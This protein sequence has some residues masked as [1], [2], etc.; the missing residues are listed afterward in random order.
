MRL[1]PTHLPVNPWENMPGYGNV[2]LLTRMA[3]VRGSGYSVLD[4]QETSQVLR[5]APRT[6]RD[7]VRRCCQYGLFRHIQWNGNNEVKIF[8]SALAKVATAYSGPGGCRVLVRPKDLCNKKAIIVEA[9][10]KTRQKRSFYQQFKEQQAK[11]GTKKPRMNSIGQ[12]FGSGSSLYAR[13]TSPILFRTQRFTFV[14]SEFTVFGT[15]QPAI[16][17]EMGRHERT[18]RRRLSNAYRQRLT[19]RTRVEMEPLK[20]AQLAIQTRMSPDML[21]FVQGQS[22]DADPFFK[23]YGQVWKPARTLYWSNLEVKGQKRLNNQISRLVE[24][25]FCLW[26]PKPMEA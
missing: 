11:Q 7:Y 8:Y 23:A 18:A 2:Y 21:D 26:V 19:D 17:L 6:V 14:T 22:F 15:S 3:D 25:G 13:G 20:R 16:A 4:I 10:A 9:I 24:Q 12:V 5:L 1:R